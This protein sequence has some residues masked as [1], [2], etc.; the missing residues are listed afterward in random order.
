MINIKLNEDTRCIVVRD[1]EQIAIVH[2]KGT[3]FTDVEEINFEDGPSEWQHLD[4]D[5]VST[6]IP[7]K[8]CVV[9]S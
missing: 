1:G 3:C 7:Q 4:E 9:L 5:M 2:P 6:F 8:N